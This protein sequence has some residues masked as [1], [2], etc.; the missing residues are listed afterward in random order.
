MKYKLWLEHNILYVLQ[1][2]KC[3]NSPGN[4]AVPEQ[5]EYGPHPMDS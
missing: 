3:M 4:L 1:E 2:S 5:L